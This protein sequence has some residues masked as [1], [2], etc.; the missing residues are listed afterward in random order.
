[1]LRT[2]TRLEN[3][4][5]SLLH[6]SKSFNGR[7][8]VVSF[9]WYPVLGL[10][11]LAIASTSNYTLTEE[12]KDVQEF[13]IYRKEE[14]AKHTTKETGVWVYFQDGVYDIT[15]F[16]PNHPGGRD[17]IQLAAGKDLAP[18][19]NLYRQHYN[20]PLPKELL[21]DMR[22]GTLH[23]EDA[24]RAA[25]T[26][27]TSNPYYHDPVLSPV[28]HHLQHQPLNAEPPAF[29][30]TD[31]WITPDAN[32]FVRNHHPVPYV[33]NSHDFTMTF[34]FSQAKTQKG[35]FC[36][37]GGST[38]GERGVRKLVWTVDE[39]K[40]NFKPHTVVSTIQCGGNRRGHMNT[41]A[42]TSGMPWG[43]EAISN[44]KWTG[45]LLRD[46]ILSAASLTED[47]LDDRT[48]PFN[49]IKHVQ[50]LGVDEM[51]ASIPIRTAV[52]RYS[53]VIVAYEMN[54]EPLTPQHGF[55]LRIIVPGHVG[56]R[57][58][59]WVKQVT[60]SKEEAPGPWQRGMAYKGFGPSVTSIEGIDV[61]A[62][63]SLQ[64]QPVQSAIT[65]PDEGA[66]VVAGEPFT[67]KGY[68]YSGGGRGIIRV[69]VSCNGGQTWKTAT[70]KEGQEQPL[71]KAWAWTFWE[72][73]FTPEEQLVGQKMELICKATDASYNVQP[74]SVA[75][76]WNLRGINNNAWHRVN[77]T[78]TATD[79]DS[80]ED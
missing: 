75:G 39:L 61:E 22:I 69:D 51:Q 64:E 1:M 48:N 12:A 37:G 32:W 28:L 14:I 16:I 13:P 42:L 56:V 49:T 71:D 21:K 65:V 79:E 68:S 72:C 9:D 36:L 20:S 62:I 34:D 19:W 74:D 66:K 23:P 15:K 38:G 25:E 31:S 55:P 4:S 6:P 70:L 45:V 47:D 52:D 80:E 29:L 73:E 63:P 18:F 59:K 67:V 44:A 76:I 3:R 2:L 53:D 27:D 78:V 43:T 10:V 5:M 11:A 17:K 33:P 24:A 60:L 30:L 8:S 46:M 54:D 57:N 41:H 26:A 77:V 35:H 50:F 58:A 7:Q 40:A